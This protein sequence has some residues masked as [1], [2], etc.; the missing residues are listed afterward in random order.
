MQSLWCW[1]FSVLFSN[2]KRRLDKELCSIAFCSFETTLPIENFDTFPLE[3]F[4]QRGNI[5][6]EN[7]AAHPINPWELQLVWNR[8]PKNEGVWI[9]DMLLMW[10]NFLKQTWNHISIPQFCQETILYQLKL[11]HCTCKS[12]LVAKRSTSYVFVDETSDA[13]P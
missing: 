11:T 6:S 1:I 5:L 4:C 13:V 7:G 12:V 10:P 9:N 8:I 3:N 2:I